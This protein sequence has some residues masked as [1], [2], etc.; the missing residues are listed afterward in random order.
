MLRKTGFNPVDAGSG[1]PKPNL[2]FPRIPRYRLWRICRKRKS[3]WCK[4]PIPV[5]YI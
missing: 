1:R 3:A 5:T 2:F 4:Q